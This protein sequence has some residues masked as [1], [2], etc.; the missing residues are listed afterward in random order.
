M[1]RT[2][3]RWR[4]STAPRSTPDGGCT[5]RPRD[6]PTVTGFALPQVARPQALRLT[7]LVLR[8]RHR[9][10][11]ELAVSLMSSRPIGAPT[12]TK[13]GGSSPTRTSRIERSPQASRLTGLAAV[14]TGGRS[15]LKRNEHQTGD[16]PDAARS[17]SCPVDQQDDARDDTDE[18]HTHEGYA[19]RG[20]RSGP[21]TSSITYRHKVRI[22]RQ[23]AWVK[24][25]RGM[26]HGASQAL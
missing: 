10:R 11:R 24:G 9:D 12:C 20:T 14:L 17:G 19:S 26:P 6:W 2:H 23:D 15:E 25:P 8:H 21:S 13:K 4:A 1:K 16:A 22:S 5:E 3:P 18:R 7:S